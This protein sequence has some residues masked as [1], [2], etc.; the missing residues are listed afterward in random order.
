MFLVSPKSVEY[1]KL[2]LPPTD[3][4]EKCDSP[5]IICLVETREGRVSEIRHQ[6]AEQVKNV[7]TRTC[8]HCPSVR[9]G[10]DG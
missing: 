5:Q 8:N 6:N 10:Q 2:G 9:K 4:T 7:N 1:K 3:R